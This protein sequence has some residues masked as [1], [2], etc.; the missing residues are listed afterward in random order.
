MEIRRIRGWMARFFGMLNR[1]RREHEFAEELESH[2]AMHIEDNLRAGMSPDEARRQALI[3]LGGV[4]LTQ[5]LHREQ[6]GSPML[7]TLLQDVRFGLRMLRKN[8]GF[9]IIA[10]L[11][12]GLGIGANTAMF[13]IVDAWMLR[14]LPF[15]DSDRLVI[16]LRNDLK[17]PTEPAYA[18]LYRDFEA[19]KAQ[20]RSFA[21]LSGLFWRR[22][23]LTGGGEPEEL[24]GMIAT[25]DLF[26]TLGV[27]AQRGRVFGPDD[28]TGPPVAV[29]S[30]RFWQRRFGGSDGAIGASLILNGVSHQIVGV[31][32]PDFDLRMLE[33]PTGADVLTLLPTAEPGYRPDGVG[34]LAAVGRLNP[35]VTLAMSQSELTII[36]RRSDSRFPDSIKESGPLVTGLQADNS[37]TVRLTLLYLSAAVAFV[38]LIACTNLASLLLART[39]RRRQ[40]LAIR[41]ALGSPRRRLLSQ[42]LTES[43]L[44]TLIG[45]AGGLLLAYAGVR[46]FVAI[47]PMDVLPSN[48]IAIDARALG[49]TLALTILTTALFGLA[50]A[51]RASRTDLNA[52]LKSG[53]RGASDGASGGSSRRALNAMVTAQ[54]ALTVVLL[55]GAGLM[56][57]TLI[58]LRAEPL[59]FRAEN[60]TLAKLTLPAEI[61]AQAGQLNSLYDRVLEKVAAIPGAQSAA[62]TSAWPLLGAPNTSC[63]LDAIEGQDP[64]PPDNAPRCGGSIV[65]PDYFSTLSIPLLQGR[66]F[67]AH[68]HERAEQVVIID[69]L[70]ARSAF[71]GQDPVGRRIRTSKGSPWRTIIGVVGATRSTWPRAFGW[72]DSPSLFLPHRQSSSNAFGPVAKSVWIYIRAT[73]QPGIAEMR[74]A[75][76]SVDGNVAVAEFQPMR[77]VVAK[78]TRQPLLRTVMLGSFAVLALL[79]AALG[80]YGVM[81]QSVEQRMRE[82]GIR[83]ALGA[84]PRD[85]LTMVVGQGMTGAL[86]GVAGG[87]VSSFAL[88]RLSSSLLYGVSATDPATFVMIPVLLTGVAILAASIPARKAMKVDPIAALRDE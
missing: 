42:L 85:A 72:R 2:L 49:F 8:P 80:V 77:D 34:P 15:K 22:Y 56:I 19:W 58:R 38:L 67:S 27:P 43:L 37:R 26:T 60:V 7:E 79:L 21:S 10:I 48:T 28:L 81:S 29:I 24:D 73:R 65:T 57:K 6:R 46:I 35:G 47:N 61:A 23:L 74:H 68:D 16:V 13:S 69:E 44:L 41:A 36:E 87:L 64:P 84:R 33:Q 50:P 55:I 12:L 32:P 20:S 39:A 3:K 52:V 11:T 1:K 30:H 54:M 78:V 53:S 51:L 70:I 62:I 9:S 71:P 40:E 45:A 14:P 17:R 88:A 82:I 76:S 86:T 63:V 25:A 59:G 18:L 4:A 83:M 66:V 31:A 5:E 75:V